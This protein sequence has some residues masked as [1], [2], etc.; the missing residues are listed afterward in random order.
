[1]NYEDIYRNKVEEIFNDHDM[2]LERTLAYISRN[3]L[4][5]DFRKAQRELSE[6]DKNQILIEMAL[7]F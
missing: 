3:E 1:M 2:S 4:T 6:S 7:P 5:S